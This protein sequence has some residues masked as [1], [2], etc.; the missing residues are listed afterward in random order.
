MNIL[1]KILSSFSFV[2]HVRHVLW[3]SPVTITALAGAQQNTRILRASIHWRA[4]SA[5]CYLEEV[6]VRLIM[7]EEAAQKGAY[8]V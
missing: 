5:T 3:I 4:E 1:W 2:H 6:H 8:F 7:T